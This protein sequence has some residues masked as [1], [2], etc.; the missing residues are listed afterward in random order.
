MKTERK[1]Y[2]IPEEILLLHDEIVAMGRL[3]NFYVKMPFGFKKAVKCTIKSETTRRKFWEMIYKLY[4]E[5]KGRDISVQVKK[6]EG[7]FVV[8]EPKK[9]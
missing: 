2:P 4:P 6:Y 3:K 1:E 9:Q 7:V 8:L 5:F